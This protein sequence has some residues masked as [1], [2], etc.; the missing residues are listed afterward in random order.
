M[1]ENGLPIALV[2]PAAPDPK[3]VII[4]EVMHHQMDYLG[5][6]SLLVSFYGEL[7][8]DS[9]LRTLQGVHQRHLGAAL[10]AHPALSFQRDV[11]RIPM[12]FFAAETGL[13]VIVFVRGD[14][15]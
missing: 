6:P 15:V 11:M 2:N 5:C 10:G 4:H 8:A 13:P 7:P 1:L 9:W 12:R 14:D 3:Y